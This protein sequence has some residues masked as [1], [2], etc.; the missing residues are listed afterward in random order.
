MRRILPLVLFFIVSCASTGPAPSVVP[1]PGASPVPGQVRA[2]T[3]ELLIRI[4]SLEPEIREGMYDP[5]ALPFDREAVRD[6]FVAAAMAAPFD[7]VDRR[8]ALMLVAYVFSDRLLSEREDSLMRDMTAYV[9]LVSAQLPEKDRE[10]M[11]GILKVIDARLALDV[12]DRE[13]R[14]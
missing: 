5:D 7:E 2:E 1:P 4:F 14:R 11:D 10:Q 9:R 13:R 3:V 8:Q 6:E 12:K